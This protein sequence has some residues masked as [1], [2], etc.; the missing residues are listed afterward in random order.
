MKQHFTLISVVL[1]FLSK[2]GLVRRYQQNN[3]KYRDIGVPSVGTYICK[4]VL[5][6][7]VFVFFIFDK[8][9]LLERGE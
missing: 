3:N 1:L 2:D 6:I 7:L 9:T 5:I 4:V 8:Q